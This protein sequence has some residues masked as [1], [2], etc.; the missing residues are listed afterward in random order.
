MQQ[1]MEELQF[2]NR[3]LADENATLHRQLEAAEETTNLINSQME[4]LRKY[5]RR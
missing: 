1:K 2:H 4:D 5:L 3:R